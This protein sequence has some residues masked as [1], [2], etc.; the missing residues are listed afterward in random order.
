MRIDDELL[1]EL[2]NL[3]GSIYSF[4]KL[5]E[6]NKARTEELLRNIEMRRYNILNNI[7]LFNNKISNEN[8]KIESLDDRYTATYKNDI[9]KIYIP[10]TM[11]KYKQINSFTYK[12]ILLNIAEITK[13]YTHLFKKDIFLLIKIYDNKKNW[14]IDNKFIKPISDGLILSKT[15]VDD[16]INS[17]F[18]CVRGYEAKTQ[19]TEVYITDGD[20]YHI[21]LDKF[22]EK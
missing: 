1:K 19:H 21:L 10:E 13:P 5:N 17:M 6:Q 9:L 11:P 15:I 14:D 3:Q 2:V 4:I 7:K 8:N 16:N 18:Y 12:R 20:K 22:C